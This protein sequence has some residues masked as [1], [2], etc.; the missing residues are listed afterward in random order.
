M[1]K[2]DGKHT[3]RTRFFAAKGVQASKLRRR[4]HSLARRFGLPADILGGSLVISHRGCGKPTCWCAD[5]DGHPHWTLTYSVDGTKRVESIPADLIDHIMPLVE[6]GQTYR[7]AVAELRA[8][9]AQLLRL[10]RLEQ[11]QKKNK[12]NKSKRP[13]RK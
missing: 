12:A 2:S 8:I 13:R 3:D 1:A 11:R 9:N 6:E 4:K 7:K 10:W 5:G